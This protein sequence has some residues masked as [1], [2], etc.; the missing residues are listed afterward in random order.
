MVGGVI[1]LTSVD[2]TQGFAHKAGWAV[3]TAFGLSYGATEL[4]AA[5][6]AASKAGGLL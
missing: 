5:R 4:R 1:R 3:G 2:H 6:Y